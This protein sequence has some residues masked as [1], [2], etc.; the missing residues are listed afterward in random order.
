MCSSKILK[1][2]KLRHKKL[3]KALDL[4]QGWQQNPSHSQLEINHSSSIYTT[5]IGS[6]LILN[7]YRPC[8]ERKGLKSL[9]NTRSSHKI[10]TI[11]IP[12]LKNQHISVQTNGCD[13]DIR[14]CMCNIF[15]SCPTLTWSHAP[16][17]LPLLLFPFNLIPIFM[18]FFF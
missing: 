13:Y 9:E 15:Q 18:S 5:G 14:I 4:F 2:R 3:N 17:P 16:S 6:G 11:G 10:I 8:M 1:I 7:L 12:H